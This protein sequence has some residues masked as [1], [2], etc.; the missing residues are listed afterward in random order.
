M[1]I[2]LALARIF[3]LAIFLTLI[4]EY[5]VDYRL[6][7]SFWMIQRNQSGHRPIFLWIDGENRALDHFTLQYLLSLMC[8]LP[9]HS[10]MTPMMR[11]WG[12]ADLTD[13]HCW[14]NSFSFLLFLVSVYIWISKAN[15]SNRCVPFRWSSVPSSFWQAACNCLRILCKRPYSFLSS[16]S[17]ANLRLVFTHNLS[18]LFSAKDSNVIS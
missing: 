9:P 11:G 2:E 4:L 5:A 7:H 8:I 17:L 10:R 14:Y 3:D 1:V 13:R 16:Q 18:F 15:T 6:R 12:I